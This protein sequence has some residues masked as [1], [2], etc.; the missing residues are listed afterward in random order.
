MRRQDN[1]DALLRV[2]REPRRNH[3]FYGKRMDVQHFDME[4]NYGKLKQ[5]LLNRLTLGKGV[6]CGLR[7]SVDGNRICVDPGVAIDGLGREIVVPMRSCIDPLA[8]DDGCCGEHPGGAALPTPSAGGRI[9]TGGEITADAALGPSTAPAAGAP[10]GERAVSGIYTIWVC[11]RECLADQQ[12]VLVSDCA[13]RDQCAAGTVVETF[14]LK[15][16]PGLPPLQGDPDWCMKLWSDSESTPGDH[17]I[18]GHKE[19]VHSKVPT[20]DVGGIMTDLQAVD[21]NTKVPGLSASELGAIR[22]ATQSRKHLL[23]GLFDGN[24]D[25]GEGVPCVP[26]AVVVMREGRWFVENCLARP[27]IYSNAMLF[28]LILCL[29]EKIDDCCQG[30][31][32]PPAELMRVRSID[33]LSRR[34]G[35]E[36]VVASVQS[37]LQD[38]PVG[39]AGNPNA[40]RIRFSTPFAQDQHAPSTHGPNDSNFD[41]HNV[42][43]LPTA[44]LNNLGYVPGVL[45]VESPD[46]IRFDL[47]P[48][49][50]YMRKGGGWQKGRY[51]LFLRGTEPANDRPALTDLADRE[52]DGEPIAPASGVFSGN[53][54][55]GG[56]FSAFFVIGAGAQPQETLRVR[57]VEFLLRAA[58]G[59]RVVA[60]MKTPLESTLVAVQFNAV[61]IA[62]NRALAVDGRCKPTTHGLNDLDFAAHNVQVLI[63]DPEARKRFGI[64][65][66]PGSLTFESPD[67]LRFDVSMESGMVDARGSWAIG[68]MNCQLYLRGDDN[69]AKNRPALGD[70]NG[71]LLDGE[72]KAPAGGAISGDGV[73]GGDFIADFRIQMAR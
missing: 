42:Q 38:T 68:T 55:A 64:A 59:E 5:W 71:S 58:T 28:D 45:M 3:F 35:S 12:P 34:D 73:A 49:S 65:Y 6:L 16:T 41:L 44:P 25:V 70:T 10:S 4:Q 50:P 51:R 67:A 54:T 22:D 13:T 7:V 32:T 17:S 29:A 19:P 11:Y 1:M 69:P 26:L 40:I 56:D 63:K 57:G 21:N 53:G 43:I 2:L 62:F 8:I 61:R 18:P 33:F 14:C 39:I 37:P 36:T 52:L 46:T 15:A 20:R 24:C 23:C 72:P 31:E 60:T 30:H 47:S 66:V 9:T 48:G 27:R